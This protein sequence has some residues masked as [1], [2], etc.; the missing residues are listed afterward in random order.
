[1]IALEE[2]ERP[3]EAESLFSPI[4]ST[5]IVV[6]SAFVFLALL[7]SVQGSRTVLLTPVDTQVQAVLIALGVFAGVWVAAVVREFWRDGTELDGP[8]PEGFAAA[9]KLVVVVAAG[10]W[11]GWM[12]T[13]LAA[14][15]RAFHGLNAPAVQEGFTVVGISRSRRGSRTIHLVGASGAPSIAIGCGVQDCS[16][17]G[18]GDRLLVRVETGRGGARRAVF[19]AAVSARA[20]RG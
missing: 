6:G 19:P 16:H 20:G 4:V 3:E 1:M 12:A 5:A 14:E 17:L 11:C 13:G 9:A 10:A 18:V 2:R 7:L 8:V 15:W